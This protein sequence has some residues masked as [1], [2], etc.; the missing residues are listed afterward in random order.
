MKITVAQ[1]AGFCFGVARATD[2]VEKLLDSDAPPRVFTI[3][4]L[5]H[6]R[7]YNESLAARGVRSIS[8][9]EAV[10]L[11]ESAE[12]PTVFVIRTHRLLS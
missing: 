12:S 2:A 1:N 7:I 5:I 6:N 10:L 11:A 9:A 3:G 4:S 8:A